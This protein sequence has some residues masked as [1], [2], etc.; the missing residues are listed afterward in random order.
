MVTFQASIITVGSLTGAYNQ[1]RRACLVDRIMTS[2]GFVM[3]FI[4]RELKP[5]VEYREAAPHRDIS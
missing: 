1:A 2:V 3:Q 5:T 4:L